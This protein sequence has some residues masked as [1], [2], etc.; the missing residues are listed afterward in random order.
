MP[1]TNLA[2]AAFIFFFFKLLSLVVEDLKTYYTPR[3]MFYKP[4]LPAYLE[5]NAFVFLLL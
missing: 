4:T 3:V 2:E 5:G 1:P